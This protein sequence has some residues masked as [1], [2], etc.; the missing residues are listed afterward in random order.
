LP[1]Q[2][3]AAIAG[4]IMWNGWMW[5]CASVTVIGGKGLGAE[6]SGWVW[7]KGLGAE[8]SGWVWGKGLGAQSR[9][10]FWTSGL[11]P[12]PHDPAR[13]ALPPNSYMFRSTQTLLTWV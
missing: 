1:F 10:G 11:R 5:M 12:Q 3:V 7:G 6:S 13:S 4:G 2:K 8:S 9:A